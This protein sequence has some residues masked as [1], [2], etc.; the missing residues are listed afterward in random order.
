MLDIVAAITQVSI[1]PSFSFV[2]NLPM[3][4]DSAVCHSICLRYNK[5]VDMCYRCRRFVNTYVTRTTKLGIYQLSIRNAISCRSIFY[6]N[7]LSIYMALLFNIHIFASEQLKIY[8]SIGFNHKVTKLLSIASV[9]VS[10]IYIYS[11]K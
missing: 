9:L 10:H 8:C 3:T 7:K 2:S 6:V 1:V 11:D 4:N 5:I